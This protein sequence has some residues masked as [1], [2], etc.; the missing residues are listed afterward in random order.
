[1]TL[2]QIFSVGFNGNNTINY[3]KAFKEVK[4]T[5]RPI[6][7][8]SF[9]IK[10]LLNLSFNLPILQPTLMI[11]S[12]MRSSIKEQMSIYRLSFQK[13]STTIW[14]LEFHKIR[15]ATVLQLRFAMI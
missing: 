8:S 5:S 2:I 14:E 7:L 15:R 6:Y 11:T 12:L 3:F 13:A 1:M 10:D 9:M 4:E